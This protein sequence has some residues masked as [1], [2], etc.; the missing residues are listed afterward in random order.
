VVEEVVRIDLDFLVSYVILEKCLTLPWVL[1]YNM[2][3][4]K[5]PT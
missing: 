2:G 1:L 3:I 4:I 5:M